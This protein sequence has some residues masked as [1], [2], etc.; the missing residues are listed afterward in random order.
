MI[1]LDGAIMAMVSGQLPVTAEAGEPFGWSRSSIENLV[2]D[3]SPN[4]GRR[5]TAMQDKRKAIKRRRVQA[6]KMA[7]RGRK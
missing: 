5:H 1:P 6:H 7:M 4:G 3:K 2:I